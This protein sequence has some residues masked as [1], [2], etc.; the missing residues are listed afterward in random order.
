MVGW[1]KGSKVQKIEEGSNT[2]EN[3]DN[4]GTSDNSTELVNLMSQEC[5]GGLTQ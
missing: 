3:E 4:E 5:A 1:C 2:R